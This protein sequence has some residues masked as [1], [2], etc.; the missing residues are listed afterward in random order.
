[1]SHKIR[2]FGK[3]YCKKC[4]PIWNNSGNKLGM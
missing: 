4:G 2:A 1:M 3:R